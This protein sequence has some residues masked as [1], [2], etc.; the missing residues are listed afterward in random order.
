VPCGF[1]SIRIDILEQH[2]VDETDERRDALDLLL[3]ARLKKNAHAPFV[4][5]ARPFHQKTGFFESPDLGRHVG[6]G[7]R[8]VIGKTADRDP[9]GALRVGHTHQHDELAGRETQL[10][11][12]G[13]AAGEQPPDALHHRIDTASKL[14]IGA[15]NQEFLSGD[16][17]G[18][19]VGI[20]FRHL[21]S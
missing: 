14:H 5:G 19:P 11:A 10:L 13:I 2:I 9:T 12:E 8:D 17:R 16:G 20:G 7:E 21:A 4:Y 6:R 15:L 1:K 3:A 18:R